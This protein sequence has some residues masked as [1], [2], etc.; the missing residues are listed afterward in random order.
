[1]PPNHTYIFTGERCKGMKAKKKRI[2]I[3]LWAT[4]DGS[5]NVPSLVMGKTN[6]PH[7]FKNIKST[8]CNYSHY[9]MNNM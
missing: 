6:Q 8:P 5:E 3:L 7:C 2:I 1:M 9:K 4:M